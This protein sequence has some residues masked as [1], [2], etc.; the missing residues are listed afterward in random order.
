MLVV[1][2]RQ[3]HSALLD[4]APQGDARKAWWD[5]KLAFQFDEDDDEESENQSPTV[6]TT[7]VSQGTPSTEE[8]ES[9]KLLP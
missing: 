2:R 5:E 4:G 3:I 1:P 7:A 6:D 9:A 8:T